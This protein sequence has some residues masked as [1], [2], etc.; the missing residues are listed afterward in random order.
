MLRFNHTVNEGFD[1]T[2]LGSLNQTVGVE[3]AQEI[4]RELYD[5]REINSDINIDHELIS[6]AVGDVIVENPFV[7]S[8]IK[9]VYR[10]YCYG[11]RRHEEAFTEFFIKHCVSF[12]NEQLYGNL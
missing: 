4:Y 1:W 8:F 7:E 12:V 9:H 2:T 11:R 6:I 10:K 3:G 5:R